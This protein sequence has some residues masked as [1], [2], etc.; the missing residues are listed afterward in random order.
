MAACKRNARTSAQSG[1]HYKPSH[2]ELEEEEKEE[3]EE[4]EGSVQALFLFSHP[5]ALRLC[6]DEREVAGG[7]GEARKTE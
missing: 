6:I 3:E 2:G 4:E 7:G 1:S 5:S